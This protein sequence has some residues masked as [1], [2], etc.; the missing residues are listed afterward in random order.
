M[1]ASSG[2]KTYSEISGEY[3]AMSKDPNADQ[4]KVKELGELRQSLFMG[5]SLRGLLLNAYAFGIMAKVAGVAAVVSFLAG[6]TLLIL[7]LLGFRHAQK[8]SDARPTTVTTV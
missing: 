1:N 5:N 7:S 3:M 2:G 6:A 8:A 4:A